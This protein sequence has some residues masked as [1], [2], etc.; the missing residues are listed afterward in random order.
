MDSQ[1]CELLWQGKISQESSH[2]LHG[3]V[4]PE[5]ASRLFAR[6]LPTLLGEFKAKFGFPCVGAVAVTYEP[7]LSTSLLEGVMMGKALA[8]SLKVPLIPINHLKGHVFSLFINQDS[9]AQSACFPLSVLLV[10]GGH[11]LILECKSYQNMQIVGN[12]LDDSFGECYDKAAKM[13][14]LGYPGGL[15]IDTLASF[16]KDILDGKIIESRLD[17]KLLQSYVEQTKLPIPLQKDK[18]MNFSFSGLKNAFRLKLYENEELL[19]LIDLSNKIQGSLKQ[20]SNNFMESFIESKVQDSKVQ[21][22]INANLDSIIQKIKNNP[23]TL[24]LCYNLQHSAT[25]HIIKKCR[26]YLRNLKDSK[27]NIESKR[28]DSK[29]ANFIESKNTDYITFKEKSSKFKHFA[30]VGGASA[31][32]M[33]RAKMQDLCDEFSQTLL[34]TKLEFCSDNAAMIARAAVAKIKENPS[35]FLQKDSINILDLDVHPRN[36]EIN[37]I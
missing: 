24:A 31:N 14:S 23:Y 9:M 19:K 36:I 37:K 33:L 13:L 4:V 32:S 26:I 12:S 30:I 25:E 7:G 15:I 27:N 11:S 21:D 3:G 8:L 29:K 18:T 20:D 35:K 28:V 2:K 1:S 22:S 5:L 17:S 16:C 10:S 6:D 34:T